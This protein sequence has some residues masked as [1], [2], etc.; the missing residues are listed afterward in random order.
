[1][2]AIFGVFNARK[3]AE[4]TYVG[5]HAQQHRAVEYAGIATNDGVN[6]F[7]HAGAG[8]V[9]EVFNQGVLDGLHGKN[10]L[11][12]IR[13]STVEDSPLADNAQPIVLGDMAIAHNGNITNTHELLG[14]LGRAVVPSTAIDTELILQHLVHSD[15]HI[16]TRLQKVLAGVRGS[17]SLVVLLPDRLIAVRDPSGNRPLVWGTRDGESFVASE[18]CALQ[19]VEADFIREV[20]PGEMLTITKDGIGS[21]RLTSGRGQPLAHCIFEKIY[22]A[23]P[24]SIVFGEETYAFRLRLGKR[25]EELCPVIGG[26]VVVPVPDSAEDIAVGYALCGRSGVYQKAIKRHHYIGRSFIEG[27]Q[28]LRSAKASRK[29]TIVP[30]LVQG[31]SVV[32]VDDSIVRLT[33]A[34]HV[35]ARLRQMGA[36][37]VH[38]RIACPPIVSPCHYGIDTPTRQEL[39]ASH[40]STEEMRVRIG[41]DS[42][43]FLP[44][45]A[46]RALHTNPDDFCYSC[47]TGRYPAFMEP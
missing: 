37:E 32:V 27:G 22:F 7:R 9:R 2:C 39:A 45:E 35:G 40:M 10:A 5:L 46:L 43:E 4:L 23:H 25:L 47:M 8:L 29:F 14:R 1:M 12:H 11:G 28:Y 36:R 31:K 13:Y 26:E 30:S 38:F 20:R 6:F 42:L 3:A 15:G 44:I 17:Y 16:L 19:A 41:A 24:A 18:S 34:P 21:E 33:T